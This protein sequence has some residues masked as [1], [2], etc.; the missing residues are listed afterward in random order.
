MH[1][2]PL[3]V[4]TTRDTR[5]WVLLLL[6]LVPVFAGAAF[7]FREW[8]V[9]NEAIADVSRSAQIIEYVHQLHQ[10]VAGFE[11]AEVRLAIAASNA[12]SVDREVEATR[13]KNDAL[14]ALA[15][16]KIAVT[17]LFE[18][19]LDDREITGSF[20]V[21]NTIVILLDQMAD[22][23]E[24]ETPGTPAQPGL[25]QVRAIVSVSFPSNWVPAE[26]LQ[27][28]ASPSTAQLFGD[29]IEW[30]M[31][32]SDDFRPVLVATSG[33]DIAAA[34]GVA[35]VS[36][37]REAATWQVA[38]TQVFAVADGAAS[39]SPFADFELDP[40]VAVSSD[41]AEWISEQAQ[42]SVVAI[43][44]EP[45]RRGAWI[46]QQLALSDATRS[47]IG[48]TQRSYS[49]LSGA[50][51]AELRRERLI[52]VAGLAAASLLGGALFGLT[53]AEI[54]RR[55]AVEAAHLVALAELDE[56]ATHDPVTGLFNRRRLDSKLNTL[57][58]T[59]TE[60][61]N[62]ALVYLDLDE[63]KGVND[64]W[65]HA[66][67]DIVLVEIGQRLARLD[68]PGLESEAVRL[69]GDE[70]VVYVW[71]PRSGERAT[72]TA[73]HLLQLVSQPIELPKDVVELQAT[74][75]VSIADRAST[76][77][78]LL[79]D[80]DTAL[81]LAK[82][83]GRGSAVVHDRTTSRA[84]MLLTKLPTALRD[85]EIYCDLQPIWN[86]QTGR[87]VHL[88]AL[89]RWK[90]DSGEQISPGEFV[91]IVEAFGLSH[92]LRRTVL[93]HV[94]IAQQQLSTVIWLN[95]SPV[96]FATNNFAESFRQEIDL[97]GIDA[98][99]LGIEITESAAVANAKRFGA[100]LQSLRE[101]GIT[102]AL[103]DFGSG[104]SA[105]GFLRDLPVDVVKIDRSII[106]DIDQD[107]INQDLLR[108]IMTICRHL[109]VEVLA[110]GVEL[111]TELQWLSAAGIRLMQGYLLGRPASFES[112]L[113]LAT[114][115][116]PVRAFLPDCPTAN[117]SASLA[118]ATSA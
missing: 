11:D 57:L 58:E 47:Y 36:P 98:N 104:Y 97:L 74:A 8:R 37:L 34:Y 81:L 21:A 68:I 59:V 29:L 112:A 9:S 41:L 14:V 38:S 91:P 26:T 45:E 52:G 12:D 88:E 17:P 39:N 60:K 105:L 116:S 78:S 114:A 113:A 31:I 101:M 80:A 33:P 73:E 109:D 65:G 46:D 55:R 83:Q 82:Q 20:D 35:A 49:L 56:K 22:A 106:S 103:D 117:P 99:R 85:G 40:S 90:T 6:A 53:R 5:A 54:K 30:W 86:I 69:G 115:P 67:G 27:A 72:S 75:G 79:L 102:I 19:V 110:E 108:S 1:P 94:A 42:D 92:R 71:G 51:L 16:A 93:E 62:L 32:W 77:D 66:S 7:A 87:V 100:Q 84:G 61:E 89:A 15:E 111:D 43:D 44:P 50:R 107:P 95:V 96:E 64:I 24:A 10:G 3:R 23:L 28:P 2:A 4:A 25:Q 48:D 70:F 76:V 18:L 63:F 118:P 13:A